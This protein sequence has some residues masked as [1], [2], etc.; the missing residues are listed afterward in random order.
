M[1][2]LSRPDELLPLLWHAGWTV[3]I[4]TPTIPARW[5]NVKVVETIDFILARPT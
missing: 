3:G 1:Q 5:D 4:G 2:Q